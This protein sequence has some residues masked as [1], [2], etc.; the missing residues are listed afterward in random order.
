MTTCDVGGGVG[1]SLL[2]FCIGSVFECQ[3]DSLGIVSNFSRPDCLGKVCWAIVTL[4]VIFFILLV[5]GLSDY[6]V[7]HQEVCVFRLHVI[8]LIGMLLGATCGMHL[9]VLIVLVILCVVVLVPLLHYCF[10]GV[11]VYLVSKVFLMLS[12]CDT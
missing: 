3:N 12:L 7:L 4:I 11:V 10:C 6:L 9:F 8:F 1:T 2:V 5:F